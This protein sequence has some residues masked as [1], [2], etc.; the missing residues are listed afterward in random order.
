M[1]SPDATLHSIHGT[2]SRNPRR[3]Q[4]KDSESIRQQPKRKRSKISEDIFIPPPGAKVNG[5]GS[6][7]MNGHAG[8]GEGEGSSYTLD[9]PVRE[10]KPSVK[11]SHKDDGS[12]DLVCT[13][14]TT[15]GYMTDM[16]LV[17]DK[18]RELHR[19]ETTRISNSFKQEPSGYV[20]ASALLQ[21]Y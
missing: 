17:L 8:R 11:R 18:K 9:M 21:P 20:F 2:S 1:F 7:L 13:R 12:L 4:R 6:A 5:N 3:R 16:L 19:Q 10:K 15:D 14:Y